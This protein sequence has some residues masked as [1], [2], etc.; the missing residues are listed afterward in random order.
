M[1]Y[2]CVGLGLRDRSTGR[3]A[4]SR[5]GRRGRRRTRCAASLAT[6][7]AVPPPCRVRGERRARG[8]HPTSCTPLNGRPH[9]AGA[10]E[11]RAAGRTRIASRPVDGV[12]DVGSAIGSGET[13]LRGVG[14]R[15]PPSRVGR[16][17]RT[18]GS[19][20]TVVRRASAGLS[21]NIR[22]IY[23]DIVCNI[24]LFIIINTHGTISAH[25]YRQR[26]LPTPLF[27]P[28]PQ[29]Q[30]SRSYSPLTA[31]LGTRGTVKP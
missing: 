5:S 19:S 30:N 17:H 3:W 10:G 23:F 24:H 4:D 6:P 27:Q 13:V 29:A 22:F 18:H 25:A 2:L 15:T 11:T 28:D 21:F 20:S 12:G 1:T 16:V 8:G 7:T 26:R 31:V 9:R 14:V